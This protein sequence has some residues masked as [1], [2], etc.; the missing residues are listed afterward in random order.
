MSNGTWRKVAAVLA[1]CALVAVGTDAVTYAATGDSLLL[2]KINKSGTT[3]TV[4]NTG[5]G[6]VLNLNG[7]KLYPPLKVNSKKKVVNFNADLLDGKD[8]KAL[9]PGVTRLTIGSGDLDTVSSHLFTTTIPAG[10]YQFTLA[11][12]I[13]SST[14]TDDFV[15]LMGDLD[16]LL[17]P[18]PDYAHGYYT[19]DQGSFDSARRGVVGHTAIQRVR[20]GST[21][22]F[23]CQISGTGPAT[24]AQPITFSYRA[25]PAPVT[26]A[27]TLYDPTPRMMHRLT[28]N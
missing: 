11:G 6:P 15:C 21:V 24:Q 17:A 18:V 26:K 8:S 19:Y 28:G 25:V 1:G 22:V 13:N 14:M 2:G 7:G 4:T 27:G 9:E 3:T 12:V 23:G 16:L 10:W 5:R 20:P